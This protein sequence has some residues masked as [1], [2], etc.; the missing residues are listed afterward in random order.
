MANI[1]KR[2]GIQCSHAN[3]SSPKESALA[4]LQ[5]TM[6]KMTYIISRFVKVQALWGS[7][8]VRLPCAVGNRAA[9]SSPLRSGHHPRS[10]SH[11]SWPPTPLRSTLTHQSRKLWT[12]TQTWACFLQWGLQSSF[13][14]LGDKGHRVLD[15]YYSHQC[16]FLRFRHISGVEVGQIL[17]QVE[18]LPV[19]RGGTQAAC[20]RHVS[21]RVYGFKLITEFW[22]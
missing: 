19:S 8:S 13:D 6:Q 18:P 11:S 2:R 5:R 7:L 3:F 15:K 16:L 4:L 9:E 1:V 22:R 20:S 17:I 10:H 12:R 14:T 21:R